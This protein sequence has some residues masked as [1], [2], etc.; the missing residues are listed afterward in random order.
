MPR[1][2]E[3][4]SDDERTPDEGMLEIGDEELQSFPDP[5]SDPASPRPG[6][7]VTASGK[8]SRGG[9]GGG[10]WGSPVPVSYTHL[11]LPTN[12]SV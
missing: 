1:R 10:G 9:G 11:T 2:L 6:F 5:G 3:D 12:Y 4:L 7:G 8:S